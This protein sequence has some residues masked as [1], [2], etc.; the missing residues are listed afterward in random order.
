MC[1]LMYLNLRGDCTLIL[2]NTACGYGDFR[3]YTECICFMRWWLRL[4]GT[5]GGRLWFK[6][7]NLGVEWSR[8]ALEMVDLNCQIDRY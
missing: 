5:R 2:L 4:L 6:S 7:V 8:D 3:S 1:F